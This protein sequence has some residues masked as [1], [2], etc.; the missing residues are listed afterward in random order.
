MFS[1]GMLIEFNLVDS[2]SY[3]KTPPKVITSYP[4]GLATFKK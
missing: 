3:C 1:A 2:L 4:M